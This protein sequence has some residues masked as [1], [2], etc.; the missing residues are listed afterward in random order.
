MAY[1]A[2]FDLHDGRWVQSSAKK[3]VPKELDGPFDGSSKPPEDS[4]F[5]YD[6]GKT[7]AAADAAAKWVALLD[8]GDADAVAPSMSEV[9]RS[10]ITKSMDHW[11]RM[12]AQRNKL[13]V[14]GKRVELYRMQ[15]RSGNA[16][17]PAGGAAVV[18]YEV[19]P[20]QGGRFLERV[21][22]LNEQTE[23]RLAGYAFQMVPTK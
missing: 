4:S 2:V 11:R 19:R 23:W 10:R 18:L 7:N 13:G 6:Q 20:A 14:S 8:A 21:M 22:L 1:N 16:P 17:G 3:D 15:N 12:V 5:P 9:F